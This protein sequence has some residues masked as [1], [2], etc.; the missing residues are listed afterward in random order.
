MN[1]GGNEQCKYTHQLHRHVYKRPCRRSGKV[2]SDVDCVWKLFGCLEGQLTRGASNM[3]P[4][5]LL[6]A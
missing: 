6:G 5:K 3:E 1:E 4:P 2:G